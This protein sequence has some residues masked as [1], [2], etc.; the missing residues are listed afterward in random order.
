MGVQAVLQEQFP[1]GFCRFTVGFFL[2]SFL[3]SFFS[4]QTSKIFQTV[5]LEVHVSTGLARRLVGTRVSTL[6]PATRAG[7]DRLVPQI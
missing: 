1:R 3:F 5:A 2:L 4:Q 6:A 7:P